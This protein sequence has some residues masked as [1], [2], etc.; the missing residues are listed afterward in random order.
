MK[1]LER[2]RKIV[3]TMMVNQADIEWMD[4]QFLDKKLTFQ[5]LAPFVTSVAQAFQDYAAT[6]GNREE[7]RAAAKKTPA[8]KAA[9]KAPV[10]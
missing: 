10:R 3:D 2:L 7:R 4:D 9:R 8:K 5:S 6:N 1:S